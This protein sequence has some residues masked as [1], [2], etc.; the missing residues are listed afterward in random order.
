[1]RGKVGFLCGFGGAIALA[2]GCS[3]S[4]SQDDSGIGSGRDD[5]IDPFETGTGGNGSGGT[6]GPES[7]DDERA[8]DDDDD[9]LDETNEDGLPPIMEDDGSCAEVTAEIQ[10][11]VASILLLVDQSASMTSAIGPGDPLRR[12]EAVYDALLEPTTGVVGLVQDSTKFGMTFYSSNGGSAGGACPVLVD[13]VP[14]DFGTRDAMDLAFDRNFDDAMI[15]GQI[16]GGNGGDTPTGE[17]LAAVAQVFAAI[18]DGTSKAIVL[19]TDGEPDSCLVPNPQNGQ[20]EALNGAAATYDLGIRMFIVSVGNEVSDTHLQQMANVG[21]GKGI[22]DPEGAPFY[23]ATDVAALAEAF[24]T[25]ITT[26]VPCDFSIDGVLDVEEACRGTVKLDGVDLNCGEDWEVTSPSEMRLIGTACD[27][28]QDGQPHD[29]TA[30]FPC[31]VLRP[32]G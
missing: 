5:G 15:D 14:P 16:P 23:K 2:I 21:S 7:L 28:L 29:V 22:L 30:T 4:G 1:M 32:I 24:E 18:D 20:Q 27:S 31:E 3:A 19:A 25:I 26:F 6:A 11:G 17:S 9:T 12:W 10:Q 8:L 13:A